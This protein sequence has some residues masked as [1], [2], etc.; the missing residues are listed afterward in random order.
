MPN[1]CWTFPV[2]FG[3]LQLT[4]NGHMIQKISAHYARN[5]TRKLECPVFSHMAH[6]STPGSERSVESWPQPSLLSSTCRRY[7]DTHVV[8]NNSDPAWLYLALHWWVDEP[9]TGQIQ[10]NTYV[11]TPL[12]ITVVWLG[13]GSTHLFVVWPIHCRFSSGCHYNT[14]TEGLQTIDRAKLQAVV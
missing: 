10:S 8:K 4:C 5:S 9:F 1:F 3:F 2:H 12:Y 11:V 13:G 7:I 6:I 14:T